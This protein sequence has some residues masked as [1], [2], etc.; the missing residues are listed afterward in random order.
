MWYQ[1]KSLEAHTQHV[2]IGLKLP[3]AAL[4][5]LNQL[6]TGVRV[7]R[8]TFAAARNTPTAQHRKV[9]PPAWVDSKPR[10]RLSVYRHPAGLQ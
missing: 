3:R 8:P 2:N 1:S 7:S 5:T 4:D 10:D 9:F 6:E